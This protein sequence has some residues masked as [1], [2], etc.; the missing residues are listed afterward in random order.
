[1][2]DPYQVLGVDKNADK[3]TIKKAYRKLAG[4]WHPDKHPNNSEEASKKFKEVTDAYEMIENPH[5][6]Q[7]PFSNPMADMFSSIF[8]NEQRRVPN[9]EHIIVECKITLED[10]LHGGT[11]DIKFFRKSI[12]IFCNGVGG[13]VGVCNHCQGSGKKVIHGSSMIVQTMCHGCNG[14]GQSLTKACEHCDGGYVQGPECS[15]EFEIPKGVE[16]GMRFAFRG[17][18]DPSRDPMGHNGNLYICVIVEDHDKFEVI[19][20][21]SILHVVH[22]TYTQLVLGAE[23]D[24]PTL[25]GSVAFKIPANTYPNQKFRLRELGLPIF[26]NTSRGIY[27][28]ADQIVEVKLDMPKNIDDKYRKVIEELSQIESEKRSVNGRS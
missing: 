23:M 7:R 24:V 13:E 10:V 20:N 21:G 14:T 9:G 8:G 28:R 18:G 15:Q 1:M 5:K 25:E 12:C 26:N 27:N 2:I 17:M 6:N 22:V 4:Q 3:D 16:N 19:G 11:R